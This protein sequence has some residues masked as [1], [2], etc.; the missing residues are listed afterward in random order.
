MGFGHFRGFRGA[1]PRSS[2]REGAHCSYSRAKERRN[3]QKCRAPVLRL[4]RHH[5]QPPER[6]QSTAKEPSR[7]L[8]GHGKP[9][10]APTP[11][12]SGDSVAAYHACVESSA[13]ADMSWFSIWC[14]T[15][16]DETRKCPASSSK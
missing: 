5:E 16:H 13:A 15:S 14:P 11:T 2:A 9:E 12:P 4:T 8:T 10:V 3:V 6:T 1:E 7:G